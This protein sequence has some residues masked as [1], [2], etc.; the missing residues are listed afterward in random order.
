[1]KMSQGRHFNGLAALV[2]RSNAANLTVDGGRYE[3]V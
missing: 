3:Y 1:M 2:L